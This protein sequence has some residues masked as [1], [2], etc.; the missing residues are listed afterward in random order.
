MKSGRQHAPRDPQREALRE[1]SGA[2]APAVEEAAASDTASA[3]AATDKDPYWVEALAQGLAVLHAFDDAHPSLTQT[4]IAN[5]LGWG[6]SKPYR[7]VHTLERLGYLARDAS[8]R[9]FRLTTRTMHLGFSYLAH[10]PLVELAQPILDDLRLRVGAS[11]HLAVLDGEELVYLALSRT[12]LPTA[13]NIHVGSRMPAYASSIGRVLLAHLPPQERDRFLGDRPIP[14][15]TPKSTVDPRAFRKK[16]DEA[17]REGYIFNDEEY[18]LGIRSI[19]A[20]VF[21]AQGQVVA[22]INATALTA[23]FSDEQV[24]TRVVPAVLEAAAALSAGLGFLPA[25]EQLPPSLRGR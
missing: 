6:R 1:D 9:A 21:D 18:H 19:A 13:I 7:F 25:R 10:Q 14:A 16:L 3:S 20:P 22:G 11:T 23:V 8:G 24:K 17:R 5:R 2:D 4:E 15:L 12:A